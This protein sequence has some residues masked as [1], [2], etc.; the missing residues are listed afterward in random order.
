MPTDAQAR[1]LKKACN[2]KY[3][4]ICV[5]G[6]YGHETETKILTRKT[7]EIQD[8]K[9]TFWHHQS[10][11]AT[12]EMVQEL[13][14][15]A[16]R[17]NEVVYFVLLKGAGGRPGEDTKKTTPATHYRVNPDGRLFGLP[18]A[19]EGIYVE[20]GT[21]PYALKIRKLVEAEGEIDLWAYSKFDQ[22]GSALV[23]VQGGSTMCAAK[24]ATKAKDDTKMKS[25]FR[26]I[27][28]VAELVSPYSVWLAVK[29]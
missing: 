24:V 16:E 19:G 8:C 7:R 12:P 26:E 2:A 11:N 15:M 22:Q 23:S 13:G 29:Q 27:V 18:R 5:N 20:L 14:A 25:R 6:P 10:R 1:L 4:V 21:K 28:A 3:V 17:E 9:Y